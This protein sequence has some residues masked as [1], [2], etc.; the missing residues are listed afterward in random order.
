MNTPTNR[1]MDCLNV[2]GPT[3]APSALKCC[4]FC[5]GAFAEIASNGIGDFYVICRGEEVGRGYE[6]CGASTS[7]QSCETKRGASDRWNRRAPA[8][9]HPVFAFLLGEGPLNN[10]WFGEAPPPGPKSKRKQPFWWRIHLRNALT[11]G[12]AAGEP[13]VQVPARRGSA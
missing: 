2:P 1:D 8:R 4:P 9:P 3:S 10:Y 7:D 6:G 13:G 5:G 11:D 12:A